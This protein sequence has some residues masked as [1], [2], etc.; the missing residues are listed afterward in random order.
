MSDNWEGEVQKNTE[1]NWKEWKAKSYTLVKTNIQAK[2]SQKRHLVSNFQNALITRVKKEQELLK[3]NFP[4]WAKW[5]HL[6][7]FRQY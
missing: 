3:I 7:S 2:Y 6:K 5:D 1:M 4:D